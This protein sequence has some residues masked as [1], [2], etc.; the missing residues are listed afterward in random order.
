RD[1]VAELARDEIA[2]RVRAMEAA[3]KIDPEL[4]KKYFE[5][6]LMGIQVPAQYGGGDG[7]LMMATLAIEEISKVDAA[8]AIVVDVQNTL[9]ESP[10]ARY[11]TEELKTKY[12]PMLT[13]GTIGAYALSESSSG[14]D[15]F[16][17]TTRAVKKGDRWILNGRKMWITNG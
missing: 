8:A 7:S 3:G 12:L 5:M 9:V 15:A 17:L 13:S 10:L 6:G 2:P 16:G 11:G 14:S 4:F 1:A